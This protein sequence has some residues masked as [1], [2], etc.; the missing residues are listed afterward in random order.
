MKKIIILIAIVAVVA[1]C[2]YAVFAQGRTDG[3]EMPK[4]M[5][6][7]GQMN[8]GMTGMHPGM[9]CNTSM[10]ATPDGGV[11]VMMGNKLTKFDKDLNM[12][13]EAE[14]KID[15]EAWKKTMKE[16]HKMMM[17]EKPTDK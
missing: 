12:V 15:W 5:A 16:H 2:S 6:E 4:R 14:I 13:K 1:A 3:N 7:R 11:I 10:V 17:E 8:R 9:M